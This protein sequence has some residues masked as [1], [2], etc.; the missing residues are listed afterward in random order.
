MIFLVSNSVKP[1]LTCEPAFRRRGSW[2]SLPWGCSG[3]QNRGKYLPDLR[4]PCCL[5][6]LKPLKLFTVP[7][8]F[9]LLS[10]L[11]EFSPKREVMSS[12]NTL[13]QFSI[14]KCT[15]ETCNEKD[16]KGVLFFIWH[17]YKSHF[18]YKSWI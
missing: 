11:I 18:V 9:S 17:S 12:P 10:Q 13:R 4:Q 1:P 7:A 3:I 2:E 5:H 14:K 8:A 6:W 15:R 16:H